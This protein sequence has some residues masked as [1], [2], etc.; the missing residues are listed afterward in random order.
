M[1]V[2]VLTTETT[3]HAYYVWK[4]ASAFPLAGVIVEKRVLHPPFETFHP[5]EAERD[6][7]E[8]EVLLSGFGGSIG[9]VAPLRE[10]EDANHAQ[11]HLRE[12]DVDI[13]FV[14]G[15]GLLLPETIG[16][17]P[18]CLNLHGGDPE[19]YRGLDTHLWA[20]YHRDFGA[21]VT[22]L[23]HVD[24][25]L[26]RGDLVETLPIPLTRGMQLHELRAANTRVCVELSLWALNE[27]RR[28][29]RLARRPQTRVG[30]YYSFMPSVLKELCVA[31]FR[32]HT[33]AL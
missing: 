23:H 24:P 21:L 17:A 33:D 16:A 6:A 18:L 15:T 1:R 32:R 22:A 28:S 11:A 9:D 31:N 2:A 25:R 20:I 8:R 14:F 13:A 30:R 5:F 7:Y 3:H 10:V 4:L 26:D 19:A 29:G 27:L 12:L